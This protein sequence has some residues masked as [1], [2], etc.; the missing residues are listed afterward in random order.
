MDKKAIEFLAQALKIGRLGF[1]SRLEE[2][3]MDRCGLRGNL[4]EIIGGYRLIM[5]LSKLICC[6]S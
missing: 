4:L 1:G 2:L 5:M 6:R 3:R